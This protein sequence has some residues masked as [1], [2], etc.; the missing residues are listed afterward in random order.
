MRTIIWFIYF[1]FYLL[2]LIPKMK[3]AQ[4]LKKQG[5]IA[6][7]DA[8]VEKE[9]DKWANSLLKLA[10]VT[11]QVEGKENIPDSPAIFVAN[12]QGNFDIPITLT[13]LGKPM[14]LIAKIETMKIPLIRDWMELL[15]CVF[16]DRN[17]AR[18]A[19]TALNAAAENLVDNQRSFII[20]PEGT[21]SRGDKVG[22]FKSGAFKIAFKAKA[23]IVPVVI[24]GSYKAME[25]NKMW[26]KPALVKVKIL[27]PIETAD[28]S[29]EE[30]KALPDKVREIIS[31]AKGN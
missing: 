23:T 4:K 15:Q 19:V 27:A 3:K 8:I 6:E 12:H 21:R 10:G 11:L 20:F 5:K 29:K 24:D 31:A 2:F 22:E 25:A 13:C 17:N 16:I 30:I 1:W 14:G 18:Q 7:C 28:K 26:I 9:V